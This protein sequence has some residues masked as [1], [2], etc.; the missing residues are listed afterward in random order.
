[1]PLSD[2]PKKVKKPLDE[3]VERQQ[4]NNGWAC[5]VTAK[6][7]DGS[8]EWLVYGITPLHAAATGNT[9]AMRDLSGKDQA[10]LIGFTLEVTRVNDPRMYL[11]DTATAQTK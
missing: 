4:L 2:K 9:S 11:P 10:N 8:R 7:S 6:F 5:R 3:R 1:M